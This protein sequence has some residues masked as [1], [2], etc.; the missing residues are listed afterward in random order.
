ME[1]LVRVKGVS[2]RFL[3]R[4]P[5][6][7]RVD[8]QALSS[9]SF[10]IPAGGAVAVMGANGS[11]KSTLARILAGLVEPDAG[12][13]R[14]AGRPILSPADA[15]GL[16]GFSGGE[17]RSLFLRLTVREN[18]RYAAGLRGISGERFVRRLDVVTR[19]LDLAPLLEKR[20]ADLSTGQ[21]QAVI[22]A[23]ALFAESPVL[24]M[25]EP[26][27]SLDIG[28]KRAIWA[29]LGRLKGEG[30]ALF[31]ATHDPEEALSLGAAVLRL[32]AGRVRSFEPAPGVPVKVTGL[33]LDP[34]A[35]SPFS[36]LFAGL[37]RAAAEEGGA[38]LA[39][40]F[41]LLGLAAELAGLFFLGRMF[42]A[43]APAALA[44]YGGSYFPFVMVWFLFQGFQGAALH[45]FAAETRAAQL[46][47]TLEAT[48][49]GAGDP[50]WALLAGTFW[51]FL[52]GLLIAAV[53]L[54]V[55]GAVRGGWSP[56]GVC[57]AA[58]AALLSSAALLGIGMAAAGVV[59]AFQRGNALPSVFGAVAPLLAGGLYPPEILPEWLQTL[60]EWIPQ[61]PALRLA[62]RG[63]LE[64]EWPAD[65]GRDLS[66]L[67]LFAAAF[68][69]A[70]IW[71]FERGFRAARRR[72][73]LARY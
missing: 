38:W 54:S 58:A 42:G 10:A 23:R 37:R 6:S 60:A 64:G 24:V 59:L 39:N 29:V 70:G 30:K 33:S 71:A 27:R 15:A 45:R 41:W 61:T 53:C 48:V 9:V 21:K 20:A 11:G 69:S 73:V 2:K 46:S 43:A 56:A 40:G 22:L 17:E 44:P 35:I 7:G 50:R 49:A 14:I 16:V 68:L 1:P 36:A 31:V 4:D 67:F 25:D 3:R 13:V 66:V 62:R 8:I 18:L 5:L 63:L 72:G 55:W 28:R 57:L 51:G 12:H 47:G 34:G 65:A 32:E 19:D 52:K 26:T